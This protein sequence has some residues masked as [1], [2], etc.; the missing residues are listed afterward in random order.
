MT[1]KNIVFYFIM[2][3]ITGILIDG[4]IGLFIYFGKDK[5]LKTLN[6]GLKEKMEIVEHPYKSYSLN[7]GIKPYA[8]KY[9]FDMVVDSYGHTVLQ[10]DARIFDQPKAKDELRI[11]TL[12]G[13]TTYQPWA[14]I[15]AELLN[16]HQNLTVRAVNGGTGGYTSMEN[17]IDLTTSG[18]AYQPDIV[19]AYLPI[20]DI[21]WA[22]LYSKFKRDYT[23]MR[24]PFKTK[25]LSEKP[26]Y[27]MEYPFVKSLLKIYTYNRQVDEYIA[28]N[29]LNGSAV[30]DFNSTF[31]LETKKIANHDKVSA[32]VRDNIYMMK[33]L[34]KSK[35][36]HFVLVTQKVFP[37]DN[38]YYTIMDG[39][40]MQ[41]INDII[42]DPMLKDIKILEMQK[43]MPNALSKTDKERL[44]KEF[45][46]VELNVSEKMS[47]DSMHFNDAALH[48]FALHVKDFLVTNGYV[49]QNR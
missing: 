22:G 43:T 34:C 39:A 28:N 30:R 24:I 42:K 44:Q 20:N 33:E 41:I 21:Y 31:I 48:L 23:H 15:V 10:Q 2:L 46:V 45:P 29:S 17:L 7:S 26:E 11:L 4:L 19:I 37:T 36:I 16:K 49:T 8:N 1:K 32:A 18:F 35:G 9:R 6:E 12:G 14:F 47:Y 25:E 5:L 13:S 27:R 3:S 40:T 38:E